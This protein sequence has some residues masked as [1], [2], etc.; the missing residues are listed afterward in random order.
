MRSILGGFPTEKLKLIK[1][2]GSIINDVEALVEP[3][4]IFV[5]DASVIIEEGDIFERRLSN[6]A[7]ENYEVLDRG[8]YNGTYEI[9]DHYQVSVRK[10]TAKSY[11]NRITYNITNESGKVN[12]HSVDNSVNLNISLSDEDEALFTTLKE[13]TASID[14]SDLIRQS[15]DEMRNNVGKDTFIAKYNNFIQSIANHMTVF[16]PFIPMLSNFLT[17]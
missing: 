15:I 5:D 4:K 10:T 1:S 13:L 12:I 9:P 11:S 2:D 14:N 7:V 3:K 16:A 17:R 8:F 6:G